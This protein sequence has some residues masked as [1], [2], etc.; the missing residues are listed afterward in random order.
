MEPCS[1]LA[2]GE[3]ACQ[4]KYHLACDHNSCLRGPG[5]RGSTAGPGRA[6][7]LPRGHMQAV[8]L[9]LQ[10][11]ESGQQPCLSP[12]PLAGQKHAWQICHLTGL[13]LISLHQLS[14][15]SPLKS[16]PAEK[17][18]EVKSCRHAPHSGWAPWLGRQPHCLQHSAAFRAQ[19]G[20]GL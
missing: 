1:S 17:A 18:A 19:Q 11:K 3:A 7:G 12:G 8:Q 5:P 4:H 15:L 6:R 16:V 20:P 13:I 2:Q 10:R 9:N 14:Q